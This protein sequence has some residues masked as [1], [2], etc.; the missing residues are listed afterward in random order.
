MIKIVNKKTYWGP[1]FIVDRS[2]F[3]GNKWSHMKGT[4]AEFLVATRDEACDKYDAWL[5]EELKHDG[6]ATELFNV[7]CEHYKENHELVLICCCAPER[8]HA[9]SIAKQIRLHLK[10]TD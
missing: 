3:L 4:K 6:H 7:L 2:T 9:E 5:E 8:C 10:I 1:G